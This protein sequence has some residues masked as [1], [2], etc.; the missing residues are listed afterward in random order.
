IDDE[1]WCAKDR[2]EW[3][4][5]ASVERQAYTRVRDDQPD[6][7]QPALERPGGVISGGNLLVA[8]VEAA[9]CDRRLAPRAGFEIGVA[10]EEAGVAIL[11]NPT[12][13]TRDALAGE[14]AVIRCL[15]DMEVMRYRVGLVAGHR[16]TPLGERDR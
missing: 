16:E 15:Q 10:P 2:Q 7:S 14:A 12:Q 4:D 1:V 8:H 5:E 6:R 9:E 11:P 13:V 3:R